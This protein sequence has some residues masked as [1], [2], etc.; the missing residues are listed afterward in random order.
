[1]ESQLRG[2]RRTEVDWSRSSMRSPTSIDINYW[3]LGSI[4]SVD[5]YIRCSGVQVF[6]CSGVQV[7]DNSRINAW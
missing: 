4:P 6:R 5:F 3:E 2:R 7:F 1:M